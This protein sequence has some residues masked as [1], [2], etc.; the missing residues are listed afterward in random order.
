MAKWDVWSKAKA[1]SR[2]LAGGSG[3]S[4]SASPLPAP[5]ARS[6][7]WPPPAEKGQATR[8]APLA[9]PTPA[10]PPAPPPLPAEAMARASAELFG[11]A[12]KAA[13]LTN[14]AWG[15]ISIDAYQ[16]RAR[17][18]ALSCPLA[19]EAREAAAKALIALAKGYAFSVQITAGT[20]TGESRW[21]KGVREALDKYGALPKGPEREGAAWAALSHFQAVEDARASHKGALEHVDWQGWMM[22]LEDSF[23]AYLSAARGIAIDFNANIWQRACQDQ[24]RWSRELET[25]EKWD[26]RRQ[27]L[28][29][30]ELCSLLAQRSCWVGMGGGAP[31]GR[32][33]ALVAMAQE[34]LWAGCVKRFFDKK[35][36][37]KELAAGADIGALMEEE[38]ARAEKS[39][40]ALG[41]ALASTEG[42]RAQAME[43]AGLLRSSFAEIA[44]GGTED[45]AG[46]QL[47]AKPLRA[48]PWLALILAEAAKSSPELIIERNRGGETIGGMLNA[49]L[50]AAKEAQGS[51]EEKA[52][53]RLAA[54]WMER[55]VCDLL[56]ASP[57]GA[58]MLLPK[59]D[60]LSVCANDAVR[61]A[62][63]QVEISRGLAPSSEATAA[64]PARRL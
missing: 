52:R 49:S 61:V 64:A 18:N 34:E 56:R 50:A 20:G 30:L 10:A 7:P 16:K 3:D 4:R 59:V 27:A 40:A 37:N 26:S 38:F 43:L 19:G 2:A 21:R 29:G 39:C 63:E 6:G 60:F 51:E 11:M 33:L 12:Q 32:K 13:G 28:G 47:S 62:A 45:W 14:G 25:V 57:E 23:D 8:G 55:G 9:A 22:H 41:E 35:L 15:P 31:D 53:A 24:L 48:S 17:K 54:R 36:K 1:A 58:G 46:A 5:R 42:G 44:P